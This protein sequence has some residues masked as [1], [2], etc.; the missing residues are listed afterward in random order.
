MGNAVIQREKDGDNEEE[1]ENHGPLG[2]SEGKATWAEAGIQNPPQQNFSATLAWQ[3]LNPVQGKFLAQLKHADGDSGP[4]DYKDKA[5]NDLKQIKYTRANGGYIDFG[6]PV[7]ITSPSPYT[8]KRE[9]DNTDIR[10]PSAPAY[11]NLM[12]AGGVP[13]LK[14]STRAQHFRV[15]NQVAGTVGE[16]GTGSSPANLTWHHKDTVGHMVCIDRTVH[17]KHGHNGGKFLW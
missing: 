7:A 4:K 1:D 9:N 15:A 8:P 12:T 16:N 3:L 14:N 11:L 5:G 10:D 17:Q 2:D 6:A 13:T